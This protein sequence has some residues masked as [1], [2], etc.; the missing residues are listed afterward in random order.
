MSRSRPGRGS[1]SRLPRVARPARPLLAVAAL[2]AVV[3][4]LTGCRSDG[5]STTAAP[6]AGAS[7]AGSAQRWFA[8]CPRSSGPATGSPA[9]PDVRLTCAHDGRSVPL[10]R[11]Y[12]KP[13][14]INL[15]AS[16]CAPCRKEL[17]HIQEYADQHPE[18]VVL[19]VD[20]HD[21][22]SAAVSFARAAKM[23]LPTLFDPQQKLLSGVG[24]AALPATLLVRA[25]GSLAK[26]YNAAALSTD[27]LAALVDKE[28]TGGK[29]R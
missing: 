13:T 29:Q 24:R 27:L 6:T 20:T 2:L 11:A 22:R 4:A 12:G 9:L 28:L 23:R 1:R 21:T 5:D 26:T 3:G 25:D 15:W 19:T 18:V 7:S 17:P 8:A 10:N 16:W 14:V